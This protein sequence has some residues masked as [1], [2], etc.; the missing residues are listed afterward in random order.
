[1]LSFSCRRCVVR[2][3]TGASFAVSAL[4]HCNRHV[5]SAL[6]GEA[7]SVILGNIQLS[8]DG[9]LKS[10]PAAG[11]ALWWRYL[12]ALLPSER[13]PIAVVSAIVDRRSLS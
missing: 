7:K 12:R 4:T 2:E 5:F 11:D 13:A 10:F 3:G 1:M 9:S 8:L 6:A